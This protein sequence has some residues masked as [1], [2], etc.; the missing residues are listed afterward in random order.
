MDLTDSLTV[1]STG[2]LTSQITE[3]CR[4]TQLPGPYDP[5]HLP[6]DLR[7]E[8]DSYERQ[9]Q[10]HLGQALALYQKKSTELQVKMEEWWNTAYYYE[11]TELLRDVKWENFYPGV[12]VSSRPYRDFI[13][14]EENTQAEQRYLATQLITG[15]ISKKNLDLLLRTAQG[16]VCALDPREDV[17]FGEQTLEECLEMEKLTTPKAINAV[18]GRKPYTQVKRSDRRDALAK[19]WTARRVEQLRHSQYLNSDWEREDVVFS[20]LDAVRAFTMLVFKEVAD[21]A[22]GFA[23]RQ[24]RTALWEILREA[25]ADGDE[26]NYYLDPRC[27]DTWEGLRDLAEAMKGADM[28]AIHDAHQDGLQMGQEWM[29][30]VGLPALYGAS[31]DWWSDH[32]NIEDD[33]DCS[34]VEDVLVGKS[35]RS[36]YEDVR[37]FYLQFAGRVKDSELLGV[38]QEKYGQQVREVLNHA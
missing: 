38:T 31:A 1:A 3:L 4:S 13:E 10:Y 9:M 27:E 15:A 16:L 26:E 22:T 18:L 24:F 19:V 12:V 11:P 32:R 7:N 30:S 8:Q 23:S 6:T 34:D 14:A 33:P 2:D 21:S 36:P 28:Q 20:T 5:K 25:T 35:R 29:R 37:L 17:F